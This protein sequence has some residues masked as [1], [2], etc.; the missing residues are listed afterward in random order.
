MAQAHLILSDLERS[1]LR[2]LGFR[3]LISLTVAE[4]IRMLLLTNN[5]KPYI[6]SPMAPSHS[7]FSDLPRKNK[8]GQFLK[9]HI[10]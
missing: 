2:S 10:S 4:L 3:G 5:R 7:P 6:G 1:K 8:V 9:F